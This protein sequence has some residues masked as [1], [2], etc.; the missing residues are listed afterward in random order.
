MTLSNNELE[1][2]KIKSK[3]YRNETRYFSNFQENII[4]P[5]VI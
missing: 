2:I 1:R 4:V 5:I 3:Y